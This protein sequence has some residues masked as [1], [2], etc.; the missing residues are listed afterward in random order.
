MTVVD[1]VEYAMDCVKKAGGVN[2][3]V[4]Y[5]AGGAL[6]WWTDGKTHSTLTM[7]AHKIKSVFDVAEHIRESRFKFETTKDAANV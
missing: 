4:T 6:V 2:P 3:G 5:I 1:E 7:Y